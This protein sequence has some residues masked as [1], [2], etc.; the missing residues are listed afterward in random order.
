MFAEV[1]VDILNSETDK[2]FDYIIPDNLKLIEGTRVLVPFGNRKIE[3]YVIKIKSDSSVSKEKLKE[4]IKPIDS[5]AAILPEMLKLKDFM[6]RRY[7]LRLAD[8]LRLFIPSE[9]RSGKVKPIFKTYCKL[10]EDFNLEEFALTLKKNAVK[11]M[12]LVLFLREHKIA[13]FT[14]LNKDFG[15]QAVKKFIDSPYELVDEKIVNY[16]DFDEWIKRFNME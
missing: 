12:E 9:M 3:G 10:N 6:I 16:Y 8:T 13:D 2:V 4:I 7:N 11:Q 15:A 1:I 5:F 14:L